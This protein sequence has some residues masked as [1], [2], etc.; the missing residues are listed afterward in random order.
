MKRGMFEPSDGQKT[1]KKHKGQQMDVNQLLTLD[2]TDYYNSKIDFDE[3]RLY[4]CQPTQGTCTRRFNIQEDAGYIT[5]QE[6]DLNCRESPQTKRIAALLIDFQNKKD[7]KLQK[8]QDFLKQSTTLDYYKKARNSDIHA[9][10]A[11]F[12][13]LMADRE[14]AKRAEELKRAIEAEQA[15]QTE[16]LTRALKEEQEKGNQQKA[17]FIEKN[18]KS[19]EASINFYKQ[20]PVQVTTKIDPKTEFE[21]TP[22]TS[23]VR[24]FVGNVLF[25]KNTRVF[26]GST[27]EFHDFY[28]NTFVISLSLR[29]TIPLYWATKYIEKGFLYSYR[30]KSKYH[31]IPNMLISCGSHSTAFQEFERILAENSSKTRLHPVRYSK[32]TPAKYSE[33]LCSFTSLNGFFNPSY[34]DQVLLCERVFRDFFEIDSVYK[35]VRFNNKKAFEL[36]YQF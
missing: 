30:L 8:Y 6:C 24:V 26:H 16:E 5:S 27:A 13:K 34:E 35:V 23:P 32:G 1:T 21:C 29:L 20:L 31:E 33:D 15:K 9:Y 12:E 28:P 17:L 18:L 3:S 14:Q 22:T 4:Y 25:T 7:E 19:S 2:E 10:N 11:K 36:M